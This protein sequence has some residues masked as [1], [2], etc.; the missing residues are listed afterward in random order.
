[1]WEVPLETQQSE[2]VK[3]KILYQTT[4]PKLAQ[5]LHAALFS[6]TTASTLKAIKQGFLK[7]WPSLT[8][9]LTNKNLE[10]SRNTTMGH[11]YTI[12]KGL[13]STREKPSDTDMD[14]KSKKKC[15]VQLWNLL[16]QS[17][18]KFTHIYMDAYP[19]HQA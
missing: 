11:L 13:Q 5:Y 15:F 3:N 10:N 6:P 1:M 18:E 16:Q 12:R 17:K 2:A 8:E 14:E 19:P 9:K 7:T 4:K